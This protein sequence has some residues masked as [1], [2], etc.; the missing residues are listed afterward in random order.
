[1]SRISVP[2]TYS[3]AEV[4]GRMRQWKTQLMRNCDVFDRVYIKR[5][6]VLLPHIAAFAHRSS[7][8]G[9]QRALKKLVKLLGPGVYL[10]GVR[11]NPYPVAVFSYLRPRNS[12]ITN[13]AIDTGL[14]Q[15]CV[16][17]NYITIGHLPPNDDNWPKMKGIGI[18][19]GYWTMEIPDHALGRCIHRTGL[20]PDKII[21]EAHHN[22][23][24]LN[25]GLV[26]VGANAF[27]NNARFNVRAGPGGFTCTFRVA[28]E[29]T[30][31]ECMA[32]IRA[33]TW[34]FDEGTHQAFLVGHGHPGARLVDGWL[35]PAPMRR[36]LKEG[37]KI[38]CELHDLM[39]ELSYR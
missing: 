9:K 22:V 29:V 11:F 24:R 28:E 33:D 2:A 6:T 37:E 23:L 18:G 3:D 27:D 10:E 21:R 35:A 26:L 38:K 20:L 12:V 36:M 16:T 31:G 13:A 34:I 8:I 15:D 1:M 19:E 39:P 5:E 4:R 30:R 32:R 7:P 14:M 17:V 25:P